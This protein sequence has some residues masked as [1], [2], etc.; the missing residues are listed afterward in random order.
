MT[1]KAEEGSRKGGKLG[2]QKF[3]FLENKPQGKW[4]GWN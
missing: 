2:R 4:L 3:N 1:W